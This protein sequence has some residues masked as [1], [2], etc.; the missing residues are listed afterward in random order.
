MDRTKERIEKLKKMDLDMRENCDEEL[1]Y[2]DWLAYGVPDCADE[3]ILIFIAES[4]KNYKEVVECYEFC[5]EN[6]QE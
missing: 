5:K 2:T 6:E 1:F 3:D 4:N